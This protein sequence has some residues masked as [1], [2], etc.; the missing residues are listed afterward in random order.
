MSRCF[1]VFGTGG[2]GRECA[3]VASSLGLFGDAVRMVVDDEHWLPASSDAS[4]ILPLSQFLAEAPDADIVIG[5][6][7][8]RMRRDLHGRIAQH[9]FGFPPLVSAHAVTEQ[10]MFADGIVIFPGCIVSTNVEIAPHVH[11]NMRCSV[12]HDV[13]IG[14]YSSLSPGVTICGH[15]DIGEGVFIGAGACVINGEPSKR[16]SIGNGAIIAA[17]ACVISKV[18][19]GAK[20]AGVPAVAIG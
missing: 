16:L 14:A 1:A 8:P 3:W 11:L 9:G 2:H 15:V 17:G 5:V 13:S 19:A 6:G 18:P 20:V 4:K 7:H 12:S 10:K